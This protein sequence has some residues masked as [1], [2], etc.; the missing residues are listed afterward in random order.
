MPTPDDITEATR[1]ILAGGGATTGIKTA[2]A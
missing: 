1:A 2:K